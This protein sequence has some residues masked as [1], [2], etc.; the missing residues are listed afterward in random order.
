MSGGFFDYENDKIQD[1]ADRILP[2][3]TEEERELV[4]IMKAFSQLVH[5]YDYWKCGDHGED[6]FKASLNKFKKQM[7]E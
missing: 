2:D 4:K 7:K 3:T 6:D 1:W 5:D